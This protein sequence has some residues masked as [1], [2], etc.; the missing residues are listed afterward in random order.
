MASIG[1]NRKAGIVTVM[2]DDGTERIWP[3]ATFEADPAACVAQTGNGINAPVPATIKAS[4]ARVAL[5]RAGLLTSVTALVDDPATDQEIRIFWEYE[6][7]LDR[8]S[9]AL[10]A[11]AA[12]LGLTSAQLDDL[13][14][15]ASQVAI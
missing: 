5:H 3:L 11:M 1:Y 4:Q 15:T 14:R 9:P 7:D 8:T 13:F 6:V 12:A 2:A 10:N